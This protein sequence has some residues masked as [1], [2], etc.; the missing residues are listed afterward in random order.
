MYSHKTK[1][2]DRLTVSTKKYLTQWDHF[3]ENTNLTLAT[4]QL[5]TSIIESFQMRTYLAMPLLGWQKSVPN[6]FSNWFRVRSVIFFS[7]FPLVCYIPHSRMSG[8][9][10]KK[11]T[12]ILQEIYQAKLWLSLIV[13][14]HTKI[15]YWKKVVILISFELPYF[16]FDTPLRFWPL[17]KG[18]DIN[19]KNLNVRTTPFSPSKRGHQDCNDWIGHRS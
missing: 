15:N 16:C 19:L 4:N 17:L 7:L 3:S 11:I 6:H 10:E 12:G 18:K 13:L 2:V 8:V 1:Q 5:K 14:F 9:S